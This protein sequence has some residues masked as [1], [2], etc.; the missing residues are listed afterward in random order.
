M[1]TSLFPEIILCVLVLGLATGC[2]ENEGQ[3]R[4]RTSGTNAE[5]KGAAGI[6]TTARNPDDT[7]LIQNNFNS[8]PV[9]E[10][11]S[12]RG[13]LTEDQ[14][15]EIVKRQVTRDA[16][17]AKFEVNQPRFSDGKWNVPVSF[18]PLGPGRDVL[19]RVSSNGQIL[20]RRA[21]Y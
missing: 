3:R 4:S 7:N 13:S 18:L 15:V 19:Y 5:V 10:T 1:K 14:I 12:I 16:G 9:A 11:T 2:N 17:S 21:G 8:Q 6:D 20:E